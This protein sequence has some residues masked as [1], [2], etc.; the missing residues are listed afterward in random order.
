MEGRG[1]THRG[2]REWAGERKHKRLLSVIR[3]PFNSPQGRHTPHFPSFVHSSSDSIAYF[4]YKTFWC[5]ISTDC[6]CLGE[7]FNSTDRT[8]EVL[9]RMSDTRKRGRIQPELMWDLRPHILRNR[10]SMGNGRYLCVCL[11]CVTTQASPYTRHVCLSKAPA[12]IG[13][14][15][16]STTVKPSQWTSVI[17]IQVQG[18]STFYQEATFAHVF[19][20]IHLN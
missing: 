15:H 4:T 19:P 1:K 2:R 8:L 11:T 9:S 17:P 20:Q 13:W 7:S 16:I 10:K 18:P 12:F 5:Q 14:I 3:P 6:F